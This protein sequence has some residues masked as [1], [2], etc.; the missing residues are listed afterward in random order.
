MATNNLVTV[1][2]AA[3]ERGIQYV[4]ISS[5]LAKRALDE[6]AAHRQQHEK[7]ATLIVPLLKHMVDAKVVPE[8][9]SKEAED[10]LST[11]EGTAQLLKAAVDKIVELQA[12]KTAGDLGMAVNENESGVGA[13]LSGGAQKIGEYNSLTN[14]MVGGHT[15]YMKESDKALLRGAG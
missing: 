5:M 11:H 12:V 1:P 8:G 6:V 7:A 14:P 2:A 13:S 15:P 3:L 4:E 9:R 10:L